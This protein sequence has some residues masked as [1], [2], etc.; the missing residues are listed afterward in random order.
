M[1]AVRDRPERGGF[2]HRHE[3]DAVVGQDIVT[4]AGHVRLGEGGADSGGAKIIGAVQGDA[5]AAVFLGA[6][7]QHG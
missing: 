5:L 2:A 3:V 6:V 1:P 4:I 7:G